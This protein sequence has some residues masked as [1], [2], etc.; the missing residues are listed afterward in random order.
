MSLVDANTVACELSVSREWVYRHAGELGGV[1][2]A[3]YPNA[4]VRFDLKRVRE[5]LRP[6]SALPPAANLPPSGNSNAPRKPSRVPL[7]PVRGA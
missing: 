7:L 6:V 3:D 4:P 5:G 2:L 1:K